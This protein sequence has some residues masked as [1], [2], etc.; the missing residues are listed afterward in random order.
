MNDETFYKRKCI[1][2]DESEFKKNMVHPVAWSKKGE[3]AEVDVEAEGTNLSILG[4]IS[5]YGLITVSQQV[6][7]SNRKKNKRRKKNTSNNNTIT[8]TATTITTTFIV[9]SIITASIKL[10]LL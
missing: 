6:P 5:A 7:K 8:I 2:V 10:L 1:F 4:C 3:P 9:V